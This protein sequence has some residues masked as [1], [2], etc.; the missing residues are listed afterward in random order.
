[1]LI[2]LQNELMIS[3]DLRVQEN[4]F[5]RQCMSDLRSLRS[6]LKCPGSGSYSDTVSHSNNHRTWRELINQLRLHLAKKIR[7]IATLM[8]Q[9]DDLPGRSELTQYQRRFLELYGQ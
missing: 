5:R 4:K 1:I 9:L 3:N 8:R 6:T 7:L 2:E